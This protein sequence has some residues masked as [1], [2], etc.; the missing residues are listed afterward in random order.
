MRPEVVFP[1]PEMLREFY[2]H[3][4]KLGGRYV[5]VVQGGKVLGLGC[6]RADESRWVVSCEIRP[7]VRAEIWKYRRYLL[8]AARK[9]LQVAARRGMSLH[10]SAD[11]SVMRSDAFLA[12]LGFELAQHDPRGNV[13]VRRP[14]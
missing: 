8:L 13:Y 7:E 6:I 12:H 5:A 2:G 10:A 4:P 3:P 9:L 1:T 11:P 14:L